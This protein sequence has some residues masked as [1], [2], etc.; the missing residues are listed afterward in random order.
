MMNFNNSSK[1]KLVQNNSWCVINSIVSYHSALIIFQLIKQTNV[2]V[3]M[4][5]LY[6]MMDV[7]GYCLSA[8]LSNIIMSVLTPLIDEDEDDSS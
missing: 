3:N 2:G 4:I 7:M 1:T 5:L 8:D 6:C